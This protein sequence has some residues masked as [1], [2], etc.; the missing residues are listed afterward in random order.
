MDV[1]FHIWIASKSRWAHLTKVISMPV[2][3]R[4]GEFV[5]FHAPK[6]SDYVPWKITQITHL[7]SDGI[8]VWTELLNDIDGRSYSFENEAEFDEYHAAYVTAGWQ[9]P[10]GITQNTRVRNQM[11]G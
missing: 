8:E 1:E 10:R 3:P 5:K 6:I 7:E 11:S 2:I 4:T 9:C